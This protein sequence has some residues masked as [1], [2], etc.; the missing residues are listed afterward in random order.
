VTL[1]LPNGCS[2]S[3]QALF[4]SGASMATALCQAQAGVL[5]S[6]VGVT[7]AADRAQLCTAKSA[8]LH[9]KPMASTVVL[10]GGWPTIIAAK[11]PYARWLLDAK[12]DPLP[13]RCAQD[14]AWRQC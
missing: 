14:S 6:V 3:Y 2:V 8:G 10:S 11:M 9:P 5:P 1:N 13:V 7:T 4:D 12:T